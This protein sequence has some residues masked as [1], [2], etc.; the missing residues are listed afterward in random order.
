MALGIHKDESS[1]HMLSSDHC[2]TAVACHNMSFFTAHSI[3]L[4]SDYENTPEAGK[5]YEEKAHL[6]HSSESSQGWN[7][8]ELKPFR[9]DDP[10]M[11]GSI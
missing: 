9:K 1:D 4:L 10:T 5:P 8:H 11:A 7:L 3:S 6:A 2:A